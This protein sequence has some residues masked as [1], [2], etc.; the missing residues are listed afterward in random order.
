MTSSPAGRNVLRAITRESVRAHVA[1]VAIDLYAHRGF[2]NVTVEEVAAAAGIST[3]SF[4]RYFPAKEDTV[5]G[6]PG[7]WGEFV[8]DEF[9]ARSAEEPLWR[10]LHASF[11]AL[12]R[13]GGKQGERQKRG[14]RV[15]TSTA[16]LR[17]RH[18][19]KHLLWEGMLTPLVEAR[20][21]G[22][23]AAL[24]ARVIVQASIVCFDVALAAWAVAGEKRSP[25]ELLAATF[26]QFDT[27]ATSGTAPV[28]D[29]R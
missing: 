20:L 19:E 28:H 17:S 18:I 16:S 26:D 11:D 23:D 14:L 4:H 3:R 27:P 9:A 12:L 24:R 25:R 13:A 22:L 15:L 21:P 1:E 7:P 2:D 29:E 5:I 6:D 10:S 8:R